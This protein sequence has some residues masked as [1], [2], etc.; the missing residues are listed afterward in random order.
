MRK[1][2]A[3]RAAVIDPPTDAENLE[4]TRLVCAALALA[5]AVLAWRIVT[6][7]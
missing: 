4:A 7:W 6:L 3:P 5:I 2:I 1:P